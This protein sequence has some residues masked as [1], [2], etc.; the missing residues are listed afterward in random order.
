METLYDSIRNAGVS[1][2]NFL[3]FCSLT[4]GMLG[5]APAQAQTI[6]NAME[7][8]PRTPVV[9][10]HGMECTGCNASLLRSGHPVISEVLTSM[11]SLDYCALPMAAAGDDAEQ[12][13][14][15]TMEN[16]RG[17][18][19]LVVEGNVPSKQEGQ[20]CMIAG[21]PFEHQLRHAARDA[22][23]IIA[24]GTCASWGSVQK[25]R[26]NP[27]GVKAIHEIITDKPVIKAPGCP[28]IA[29]VITGLLSYIITFDR[30]PEID[31]DGRP[32]M[33]YSQ[34]VHDKC[35][36]RSHFDAGQF[37][38]EFDDEGARRGYCLYK[39]G[40]KGPT[41]YNACTSIGW[42]DGVSS[43]ITA[44]HG[45]LGCSEDNFFDKNSFY[46]RLIEVGNYGVGQNA[47]QIG[48]AAL[49]GTAAALGIHS[50]AHAISGALDKMRERKRLADAKRHQ[51]GTALT[52]NNSTTE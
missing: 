40:C 20:Y 17:R 47:D 33:F 41:T 6:I 4:A 18:Y 45:C 32:K 2:R 34:R 52:D 46:D 8:K 11:I 27:T 13:L 35:Y 25:A 19:I 29:E 1:R 42:N 50:G 16:Y 38:E 28:P 30:F 51:G 26:P 7:N 10:L 14:E 31:R 36:R 44:G 21:R 23:A 24:I 48:L 15:E 22:G 43:P 5:M 39:V 3:R 9:W 12:I 49:V 37:V